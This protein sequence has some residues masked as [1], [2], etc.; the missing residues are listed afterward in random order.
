MQ[1]IQGDLTEAEQVSA[2]CKDVD[3][4]IHTASPTHGLV[5]SSPSHGCYVF[6]KN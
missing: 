3:I 2:A 1:F 5:T 6:S 4:V